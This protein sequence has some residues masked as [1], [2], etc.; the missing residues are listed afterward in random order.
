VNRVFLAALRDIKIN[1]TRSLVVLLALSMIFTFPIAFLNVAP[2]LRTIIE[3]EQEEYHL[4]HYNIFFSDR[5]D[6]SV[7]QK[8]TNWASSFLQRN[9]DEVIV[10]SRIHLTTKT[11]SQGNGSLIIDEWIELDLI[12]VDSNSPPYINS[13]VI[14]Q[15]LL[16]NSEN[17]IAVLDSF[18]KADGL[19]VGD[20]LYLYSNGEKLEYKISALVKSI[21]FSSFDLSQTASAYVSINGMERFFNQSLDNEF[22]SFTVY[23]TFDIDIQELREVHDYILL[24]VQNDDDIQPSFIVIFWFVRE[25]SF[26]K[27]LLDALVL[28]SRY[29]YV[30]SFFIF[31]VAG[32]IIFVTMNRYVN[33]QKTSLGALYAFGV[34]RRELVLSFF[35]RIFILSIISIIIGLITAKFLVQ[36][37]VSEL[38][39]NW[40]LISVQSDLTTTS[41]LY[42]LLSSTVIIYGFT[43]MAVINLV[44]LTPY[45]AMRGKSS[46][47]KHEGILF[48]IASIFPSRLI[49]ASIRNLTRNRTRSILTVIAFT[50]A[51]TFSASLV[52]THQSIG[53]T[54]DQYYDER[55]NFD[56]EINTGFTLSSNQSVIG[57]ITSIDTNQNGIPDVVNYE[58][59]IESFVRFAD[60]PEIL[61]FIKSFQRSTQMYQVDD[62]SISEGRWF[63]KNS[64]D[65]VISRYVAG[66]LGVEMGSVFSFIFLGKQINGTVVGISNELKISSAIIIDI[67]YISSIFAPE[68]EGVL[69][70]KL[71]V[72]LEDG[73]NSKE[74]QDFINQNNPSV[75]FSLDKQFYKRRFESLA[76]SQTAIIYLMVILG[77][78]VGFVSVFTT[79]LIA[80][81]EREKELGLL[82]VYGHT[83]L[84]MILQIIIEGLF[85]GIFALIAGLIFSRS[86]AINV[87]MSIVNESLFEMNAYFPQNVSILFVGFTLISILVSIVPSFV[88]TTSK[89][90]SEVIRE[91]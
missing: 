22:N 7:N 20:S 61:S 4:A 23:F 91:E 6:Q 79:L 35:F 54:I 75:N 12:T 55:I 40:G 13:L 90:L 46:Q 82:H 52:Y 83:K 21:E 42:T 73:V 77:L 48:T 2:N 44:R 11:Q 39:S 60:S 89:K 67:D 34:K 72:K 17:E 30:A 50:L 49:R 58:P 24:M 78:I 53:H 84:E 63:R 70:N 76:A 10:E 43:F 27:S 41:I 16:P 47:L 57:S 56:L 29:L 1:K 85:I 59:Y 88:F 80:I 81:A 33:E 5:V 87:W 38:V 28:T 3:K 31:L 37:L 36:M 15:G 18:A 68:E 26:R 62:N 65:I 69:M 74:I 51:L 71:L 19:T 66:T 8:I 25:T 32:V 14:E 64:S 9:V 45:E 86:V